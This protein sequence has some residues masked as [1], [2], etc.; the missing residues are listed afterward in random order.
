MNII[1]SHHGWQQQ[2]FGK[3]VKQT[4]RYA[5]I[6]SCWIPNCQGR[7]GERVMACNHQGRHGESFIL[8]N[9][10]CTPRGMLWGPKQKRH[11]SFCSR[12]ATIP[13]D[14]LPNS[15]FSVVFM[16]ILFPLLSRECL[17]SVFVLSTPNSVSQMF[18]PSDQ[19][20]ISKILEKILQCI[21]FRTLRSY[22]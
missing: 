20:H 10:W 4:A 7:N 9:V 2:H 5:V 16:D 8:W 11:T 21:L 18:D 6:F 22:K 17:W 14:T 13:S 15:S 19:T 3:C 1:I 12:T